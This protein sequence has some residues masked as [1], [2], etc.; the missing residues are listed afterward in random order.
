MKIINDFNE[1]YWDGLWCK[2]CL[3]RQGDNK[4]RID[5][6]CWDYIVDYYPEHY[7]EQE[8]KEICGPVKIPK[9]TLLVTNG[10]RV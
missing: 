8:I 9:G 3:Q 10:Y 6:E 5:C 2:I 7:S 4:E 1:T